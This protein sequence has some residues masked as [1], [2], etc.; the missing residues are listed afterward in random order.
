[1]TDAPVHPL[2][3]AAGALAFLVAAIHSVAGEYMIFRRQ[4]TTGWMPDNGGNVLRI[5]H[6]R[7]LWASWHLTSAFGIALGAILVRL[8]FADSPEVQRLFVERAVIG[9]MLAG[10][11]FVFVATRG[12]HPGWIGLL[13][14]AVLTW[15][16]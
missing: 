2:L 12:R 1:M 8:A 15:L 16:A 11:L 6:V 13:G 10:A 4:R 5:R 14:V 3:L 9:G 7:I